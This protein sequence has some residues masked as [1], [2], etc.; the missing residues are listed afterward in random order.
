MAR[1]WARE[2][3]RVVRLDLPGIGDTPAHEGDRENRIYAP[4]IVR[5]VRRA[6]DAEAAAHG[7]KRFVLLGLCSGAYAAF[8]VGVADPRVAGIV[9]INP[10]TFHWH[11]GD[12]LEVRTRRTIKSKRF[13]SRAA[14][15]RENWQRLVMGEV[16]L[17]AVA[18]GLARRAAE[19]AAQRIR[20]LVARGGD[21]ERGF[22]AM[23]RRGTSALLVFGIED[24]GIDV[25]EAHL[26]ADAHRMR[27]AK[28]FSMVV[29]DG[30][31]HTFT[32]LRWQR[33][34]LEMLAKHFT[35]AFFRH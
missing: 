28:Q 26:G 10:L 30:P 4:T 15:K 18:L 3:F 13:Y 25:I 32:S 9:L 7:A 27:G 35:T 8:H 12:S 11:E 20:G 17:R 33:R 34:L 29:L 21:V 5:D 19:V 16:H 22:R 1:S 24:G 23:D 6:M 14:L 2:G 31:D